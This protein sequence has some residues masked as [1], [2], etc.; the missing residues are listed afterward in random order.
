MRLILVAVVMLCGVLL[1]ASGAAADDAVRL[2][3]NFTQGGLVTGHA[4]PGST[5][6]LDGATVRVGRDGLF[7]LGFGREAPAQAELVVVRP[8]GVRDHRVLDIAQR[9][10][11]IQRIDGLP[12]AMVTPE[13][14]ALL[15]RIADERALV[16]AA[17]AHDTPS[18]D[19]LGGFAWPVIGPISGVYGS[20]R[21]LN[22][23]PR[24]P[25]YGVDMAAPVG[26]PVAAPAAG[27][28]RLA[29]PDLYY[30]GGTV[31]IDHGYGL[32]STLMH[33]ASVTAIVGQR[34]KQG[35]IVGTVGATGRV[36]GP[37]LDWRMNWHDARIDPQLL[38][39]P[40]PA[41][42]MSVAEPAE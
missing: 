35:D 7:I 40:M 5:V 17:W 33:M 38:V 21:I 39:G 3:G 16:Q 18:S 22:G 11:E 29:E 42:T 25:H 31:I 27:I 24:Q 8:D 30:T 1:A 9:A 20:Q 37:H 28:V 15:D 2:E 26:T 14:P 32:S 12:E 13:D 23:E 36:T 4:T 10:Y 34:V 41:D 6:T 19:F